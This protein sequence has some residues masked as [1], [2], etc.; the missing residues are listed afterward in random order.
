[1][2]FLNIIWPVFAL[3]LLTF[4]VWFTMFVQRV[5]HM[6]RVPA[7]R[8]D[9]ATGEAARRYFERAEMPSNNLV[10][11][12]EMPVLFYALVPL[13]IIGSPHPGVPAAQV[14]LA[15]AFVLLRIAHS[16]IHIAR[17]PVPVRF[18][19]YAGSCA[20]LLAM[21]IGFAIDTGTAAHRYHALLETVAAQP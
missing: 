13:L 7:T 3:V 11:L 16:V 8:E 10:N 19:V 5:A 6:K 18:L 14:Y 4:G 9:L 1:M 2:I 15:W 12:F 21:W 17:G 20:V